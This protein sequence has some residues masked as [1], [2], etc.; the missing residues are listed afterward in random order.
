MMAGD[1]RHCVGGDADQPLV[2]V[3]HTA[4]GVCVCVCA[5][6]LYYYFFIQDHGRTRK[7]YQV[8]ANDTKPLHDIEGVTAAALGTSGTA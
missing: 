2:F 8:T 5:C 4:T 3:C 1:G 6:V 7:W